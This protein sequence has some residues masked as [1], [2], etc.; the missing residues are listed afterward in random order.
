M[1]D[2]IYKYLDGM[3]GTVNAA[4]TVNTDG[5]YTVFMNPAASVEQLHDTCGHELDHIFGN[6][7]DKEKKASEIEAERKMA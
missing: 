4:V 7:F 5:S 2:I 6:D 3:P 1:A